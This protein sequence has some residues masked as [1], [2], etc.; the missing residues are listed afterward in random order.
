MAGRRKLGS[1]RGGV[2]TRRAGR[3]SNIATPDGAMLVPKALKLLIT[4]AHTL[5]HENLC[6]H[7]CNNS[8]SCLK[9]TLAPPKS[10]AALPSSIG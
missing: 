3:C 9:G 8:Q 1:S 4:L 2:R 10:G 5:S 6:Q 7:A